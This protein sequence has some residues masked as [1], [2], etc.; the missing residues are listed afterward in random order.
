MCIYVYI[1]M[2][3]Y[4]F[5]SIHTNIYIYIYFSLSLC[6]PPYAL[7]LSLGASSPGVGAG[8]RWDGVP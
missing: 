5:I 4:I 3:I 7:Y 2:F 1:Y 8:V 6:Q